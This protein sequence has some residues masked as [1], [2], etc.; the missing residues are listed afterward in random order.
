MPCSLA[1]YISFKDVS[2]LTPDRS[3][4]SIT[5]VDSKSLLIFMIFLCAG[6][7]GMQVVYVPKM[8]IEGFKNIW[9]ILGV[10]CYF[11]FL[12]IPTVLQIMEEITWH[13]L[14]SRI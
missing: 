5:T 6:K 9:T 11:L 12:S 14:K 7:G 4:L 1:I 3:S 10:I 13:I 2:L 8:H